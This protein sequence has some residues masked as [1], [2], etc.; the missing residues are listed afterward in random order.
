MADTM[1]E[2]ILH[3]TLE[4]IY[5]L[6]GERCPLLKSGDHMTITVPPCD[7]LNPERHN[8]QKILEVTKKMMELLT[9]EVGLEGDVMDDRQSLSSFDPPEEATPD[10]GS[11]FCK[12][13]PLEERNRPHTDFP[14]PTDLTQHVS[15]GIKE[16]PD[17]CPGEL[18]IS[19]IMEAPLLPE[20]E[21]LLHTE[22]SMAGDLLHLNVFSHH[23]STHVKEELFTSDEGPL[24]ELDV[25]AQCP[26]ALVPQ[27]ASLEGELTEGE[28]ICFKWNVVGLQ[29][30]DKEKGQRQILP[31]PGHNAVNGKQ[32]SC[33]ECGK[34]C[35]SNAD[36]IQHSRVH[37]GERPFQ[38]SECGK[39]F[40]Q[41]STLTMHHRIHT[42]QKPYT[43]T[44]CGK[45]FTSRSDLTK[46]SRSHTG[47]K[48]YSCPECGKFFFL[49]F[50]LLQ[51]QED[52]HRG[53]TVHLL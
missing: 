16:E 19:H 24:E 4:I 45:C 12:E 33:T 21:S 49:Q 30:D 47:H 6:T 39:R 1:V 52:A 31:K 37:S 8:M 15:V 20:K 14:P 43:C 38:C 7:S 9:G 27:E 26:S 29:E 48:P 34:S 11:P 36:L 50:S 28:V 42:G 23:T 22:V 13:G 44:E 51:A 3:L 40:S 2:R 53:Q 17:S 25:P 18:V 5:L 46:H 32:F 35:R 10:E 41:Q